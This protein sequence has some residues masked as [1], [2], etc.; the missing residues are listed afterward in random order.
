[1]GGTLG[2]GSIKGEGAAAIDHKQ[3]MPLEE[4]LPPP[5]TDHAGRFDSKAAI[6]SASGTDALAQ[7]FPHHFVPH[8]AAHED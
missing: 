4:L 3:H 2:S 8:Y 5:C 7:A 1:M 6:Y